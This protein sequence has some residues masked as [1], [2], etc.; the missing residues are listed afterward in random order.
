VGIV[1]IVWRRDYE[2]RTALFT[3]VRDSQVLVDGG[4]RLRLHAGEGKAVWTIVAIL[5]HPRE[6][7]FRVALAYR[8]IQKSSG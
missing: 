3:A 4:T 5:P 8:S 2:Q 6:D 7:A 1:G